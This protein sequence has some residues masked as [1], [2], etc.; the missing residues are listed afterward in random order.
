MEENEA[1]D[2][3]VNDL[4]LAND[5]LR[6]LEAALSI[7]EMFILHVRSQIEQAEKEP[8]INKSQWFDVLKY[9]S[10]AVFDVLRKRWVSLDDAIDEVDISGVDYHTIRCE[11]K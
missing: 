5:A 6:A 2:I 7:C 11:N 4:R 9:R 10:D 8:K 3:Y 1:R